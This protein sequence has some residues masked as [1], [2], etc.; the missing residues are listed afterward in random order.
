MKSRIV[1]NLFVTALAAAC[2]LTAGCH[3]KPVRLTPLP[4]AATGPVGGTDLNPA[5]PVGPDINSTGTGV[6]SSTTGIPSNVPGAHAGWAEDREALKV[7]AVY[8]AFDKSA[9][10]SS[11]HAKLDAVADYLKGNAA[12]AVRVEGNCDER[13]TEEYNRALGERRA[14]AAREY[15]AH[16]GIAPDRIDTLSNGEDKPAEA[17][18]NEAAWKKNR[19]DEFVV[20]TAPK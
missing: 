19:R 3:K 2:L 4:N 18:H 1:F 13:G 7:D 5:P 15:L 9:I 12:A 6:S 10:E 17:G 16:A 8:F 11:E 14:L 20:L